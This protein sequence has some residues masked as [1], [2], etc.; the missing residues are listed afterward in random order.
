L[1]TEFLHFPL[2]IFSQC[3]ASGLKIMA[4]PFGTTDVLCIA[5]FFFLSKVY[6]AA[7]CADVGLLLGP[8]VVCSACWRARLRQTSASVR[9]LPCLG[10][11]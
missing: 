7:A 9:A 3:F 1:F 4:N 8:A 5:L 11:G 6:R 2:V 10:W